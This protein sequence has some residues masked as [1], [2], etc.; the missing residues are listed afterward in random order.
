MKNNNNNSETVLI[1][2][3]IAIIAIG[4]ALSYLFANN[5]SALN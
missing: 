3:I 1:Y 4:T 2:S 5:L